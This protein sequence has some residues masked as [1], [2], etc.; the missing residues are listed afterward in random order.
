MRR[1]RSEER[2]GFT[3]IELVIGVTI[4]AVLA[5]MLIGTSKASSGITTAGNVQAEV[6]RMSERAMQTILAD[7]RRSAYGTVDG[8]DY[9][10]VF[11]GGVAGVGFSD[12]T[13]TPAATAATAG[14]ADFGV[15]RSIVLAKTSDLDGD[16]RPEIDVDGNGYPELDG[17]GDG[18]PTDDPID[19]AGVWDPTL[20]SIDPDTGLVWSHEAIGYAVLPGP[21]G[22]GQLVRM[23]GGLAG[24]QTV[25]A[26]G[27]ERIQFD[28]PDSS[29]FAIPTGSVRVQVFFRKPDPDGHVYRSRYEA[30]VRLRN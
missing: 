28:T 5:R 11:D 15:M 2:S 29:G 25:L 7:L 21:D 1:A 26:T 17:D 16:G 23:V 19:L 24:E 3:L 8:L 20:A 12:F 10:H 4:L 6:L 27:V 22:R 18:V 30:T 13:H 14:E 9:P